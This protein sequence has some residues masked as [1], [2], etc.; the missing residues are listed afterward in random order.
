MILLGGADAAVLAAHSG[1]ALVLEKKLYI[2]YVI[3]EAEVRVSMR[4]FEKIFN[5]RFQN[6]KSIIFDYNS[7]LKPTHSALFKKLLYTVC[8][9]FLR[10]ALY[11]AHF[12]ENF[13]KQVPGR[14]KYHL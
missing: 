2:E 11:Y 3:F 12:S 4:R 7:V 1:N 8:H 14:K 5:G 6:R 13:H 10:L 9:F